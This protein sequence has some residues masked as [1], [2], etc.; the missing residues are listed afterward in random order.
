MKR[1]TPL[2]LAVSAA[3]LATACADMRKFCIKLLGRS[4][5][6]ARPD[7][8]RYCSIWPCQRQNTNP[9]SGSSAHGTD[10]LTT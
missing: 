1:L 5:M 9:V 3:L 7:W 4:K 8:A 2:A 6:Y 10:C